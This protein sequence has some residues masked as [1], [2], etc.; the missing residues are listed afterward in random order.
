MAAFQRR[1]VALLGEPGSGRRTVPEPV[2]FP[3]APADPIEARVAAA[4]EELRQLHEGGE[5]DWTGLHRGAALQWA[6][7]DED[8]DQ[9]P[10]EA[11]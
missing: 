11:A 2:A 7:L 3:H 6:F 8:D 4:A 9:A 1:Q 10:G 5:L